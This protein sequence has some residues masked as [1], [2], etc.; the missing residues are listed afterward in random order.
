MTKMMNKYRLYYSSIALGLVVAL[1]VGI[2]T[3]AQAARSAKEG[4][5]SAT[6]IAAVQ[7]VSAYFNR[8]RNLQGEFVQSGPGRYLASGKF[9]LSKPGKLR[10]EYTPPN[11]ILVVADGVYVIVKD[12]K[13]QTV[14][15]Y[16]IGMTPLKF[17]LAD[18][19]DILNETKIIHVYQ[20]PQTLSVTLEDKSVLVPGRL[21]LQFDN[22]K[23][24]LKQW[25]IIDGQ[26]QRTTIAM[27]NIVTGVKADPSLFK[28]KI[29]RN[30][31]SSN[32]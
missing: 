28:V 13:L 21:T 24:Q 25:V 19:I 15:H 23:M 17:V 3:F 18:K 7:R 32:Q 4:K 11:P 27:R 16:P 20:D 2:A 22:K 1:G 5:L 12:R 8:L 30:I 10:F 14:D 6:E 29:Q 26:G 31:E 9:Y